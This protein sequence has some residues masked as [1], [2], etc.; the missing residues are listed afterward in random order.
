MAD[1]ISIPQIVWKILGI[2]S[3]LL[4]QYRTPQDQL[5]WLIFIP[6]LIVIFFIY[7]FSTSISGTHSGFRNLFAIATYLTIVLT[8]WYGRLVPIFLLWWWVVLGVELVLFIFSGFFKPGG[9]REIKTAGVGL[10]MLGQ[11]AMEMREY[12]NKVKDLEKT[13]KSFGIDPNRDPTKQP[14][15]NSLEEKG[16]QEIII[17]YR[18]M[19][20]ARR[21][22]KEL[23]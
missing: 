14:N 6:N 20:E 15:W 1:V 12:Q 4:S 5:L 8:G 18:Q 9:A 7:W 11:K 19:Q 2:S 23:I 22:S 16:K 3:Q 17:M 21:K 13:L 10:G